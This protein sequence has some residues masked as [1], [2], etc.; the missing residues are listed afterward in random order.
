M[1]V[2]DIRRIFKEKLENKEFVTDKSGVKTVEILGASYIASEDVI[3][4]TPNIQY[5]QKEVEWY[6]SKSLNV[7]DMPNPP[8]IW[9]QVADNLGFIN[10]NYGW[11]I[12]SDDN[13]LQYN[14]CL[15]EL[16]RNKDTRRAMMIYTRPSMQYEFNKNG[17]SDFICT[18]NV[19]VFIRD[20]KLVYLINQ[21][22]CDAVFGYKNDI[23]W[24]KYVQNM[25][26]NDLKED[27]EGIAPGEIIHQVGSLHIYE[28]HFKFIN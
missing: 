16:R 2:L 23:F 12:F 10:S 8:A 6:L 5:A 25:L 15:R 27:Y 21:R 24:H 4:G 1:N 17:M 7:Y 14:N 11:V 26:C 28:R 22:S 9:K 19:Q 18:N 20:N 3:F 13:H